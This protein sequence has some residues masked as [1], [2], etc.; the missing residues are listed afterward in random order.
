M[1][2]TEQGRKVFAAANEPKKLMIVPHGHHWLP[3][4]NGYLDSVAEFITSH[5]AHEK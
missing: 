1:I 3:S 4:E 2:P 5:L